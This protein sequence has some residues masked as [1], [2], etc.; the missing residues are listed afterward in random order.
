[1]THRHG[2]AEHRQCARSGATT[3][4]LPS[5]AS[6]RYATPSSVAMAFRAPVLV[7]MTASGVRR[8]S[9]SRRPMTRVAARADAAYS[10]WRV[11]RSRC[12]RVRRPRPSS[13]AAS[14]RARRRVPLRGPCRPRRAN[15]GRDRTPGL[16][17]RRLR[18]SAVGEPST[19]LLSSGS[20]V[21]VQH[22]PLTH[23]E[24]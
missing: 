15:R 17:V 10:S 23:T 11:P 21:R 19:F 5:G 22:G 4:I 16:S 18:S 2:A 3:T 9:G 7:A 12:Y 13:R 6:A 1:M 14:R 8:P 20:L 24:A